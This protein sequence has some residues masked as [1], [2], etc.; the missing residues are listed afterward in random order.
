MGSGEGGID[1][2]DEEKGEVAEEQSW[3]VA[4]MMTTRMG[5]K[6]ADDVWS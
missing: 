3:R 1:V 4:M 5:C 6:H 2:G